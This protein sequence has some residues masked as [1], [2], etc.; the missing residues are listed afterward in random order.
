[1]LWHPV[2]DTGLWQWPAGVTGPPLELVFAVNG[3]VEV[4]VRGGR[5][6]T[7]I[8]PRKTGEGI[9]WVGEMGRFR[10]CN[11]GVGSWI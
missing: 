9:A 6:P 11:E 5:A 3:D 1:M 4:A 2:R 10:A 8:L 7:L